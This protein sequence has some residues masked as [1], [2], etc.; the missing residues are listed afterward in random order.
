MEN[1]KVEAATSIASFLSELARQAE[2]EN[3][4]FLVYLIRMAEEEAREIS[5]ERKP[6]TRYAN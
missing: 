6:V 4:P 2:E 3:L 5:G 1:R